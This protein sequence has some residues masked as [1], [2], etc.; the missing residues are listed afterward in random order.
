MAAGGVD[1]D[2]DHH[3]VELLILFN[4]LLEVVGFNGAASRHVL[5]IEVEHD[6]LAAEAIETDVGAILRGQG[7]IRG[8]LAG[9]RHRS[10]IG[11]TTDSECSPGEQ[12]H[13]EGDNCNSVC[14]HTNLRHRS[15]G[16]DRNPGG[17]GL[18]AD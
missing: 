12:D 2:T 5:G 6:P 7:E 13:Q 18:L 15:Y 17:M 1:T 9:L 4:V 11:E 3:C 10:I 14:V 16:N 8:G